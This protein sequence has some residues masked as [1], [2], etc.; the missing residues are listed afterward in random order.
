M[1]TEELIKQAKLE[2]AI[3]IQEEKYRYFIPNGRGEEFLATLGSTRYL[4]TLFNAANGVGKT[5]TAANALANI[6]WPR[7]NP[8]FKGPLFENYPFLKRGRIVSDPSVVD[9]IVRELKNWFPT[10]RYVTSK[11]RKSYE[12]YWKTDTGFD[13]DIMTYDQD[14]KEFESATLGFVWCDEPPPRNIYKACLSRLR[15]GGILFITATPLAGS[16]WMYDD[17]VLNKNAKDNELSTF[18]EATMEDAC[19]IHGV[20]GHLDHDVIAKIIASYDEEEKHARVQGKFQHLTGLVFKQFSQKIHVIPPFEINLRDFTVYHQ[21]DPHPRTPDAALWLAVDRKGTKYVIDE[22]FLKC[23]GGDEELASRLM[24]KDEKY[25]VVRWI[26]DKSMFIEDQ[27][28]Q[29]SLAQRLAMRGIVYEEASK[30]RSMSDRRIA[31]ALAYTEINGLMI[32]PPELFV[33]DTCVRT[34]YEFQHYRWDEWTG[35]NAFK[36]NPKQKPMDKDDHMIENLGRALFQ[37]P[38]FAQMEV[39]KDETEEPEDDPYK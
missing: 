32:K 19:K 28:T 26:G 22:L 37:E 8:Y 20:R 15:K 2:R 11:G 34:I 12:A 18:I 31:D 23:Q 38:T 39:E 5:A 25:R 17:I 21:L 30:A 7:G 29:T 1:N 35:K 10:G 24:A 4:S 3:R 14:P 13:F 27:H 6:F 36:H 16:E 9:N 33:F